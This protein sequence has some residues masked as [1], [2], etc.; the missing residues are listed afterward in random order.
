VI[1]PKVLNRDR[2]GEQV[3]HP[4]GKIK[5]VAIQYRYGIHV[6]LVRAGLDFPAQ[7]RFRILPFPLHRSLAQTQCR[8]RFVSSHTEEESAPDDLRLAWIAELEL[9]ERGRNRDR[10]FNR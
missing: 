1:R 7:E 2:L 8:C 10:V 6:S 3:E 4:V 5:N 9:L